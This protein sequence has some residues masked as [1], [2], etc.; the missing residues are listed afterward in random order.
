MTAKDFLLPDLGEGLTE[1]EIVTWLVSVGDPVTVDQPVAEVETAKAVV[2]VPSPFAGTVTA[3]HGEVGEEVEVGTPLVSIEVDDAR[4]P[5]AAAGTAPDEA[6]AAEMVPEPES[7]DESDSGSVLVGY[8]TGQSSRARRRRTQAAPPEQRPERLSSGN[9]DGRAVPTT[10]PPMREGKP[11][12]KPP[13]RKLAK[14]LGVDLAEVPASGPDGI[15]TREDVHAFAGD[16]AADE[17]PAPVLASASADRE[18]RRPLRGVRK[19]IAER[20]TMS[21]REIPEAT[22]EVDCDATA[23]WQARNEINAAQDE[24]AVSPL[25]LIMRACVVGLRRY[26]ELNAR[27][28]TDRNE[29][30]VQHFVNLGFAAQTDRGL[31]VP[32]IKGADRMTT[33]EIAAELNRLA[34]AARDAK[35][36]PDE[37]TGGTFTLSNYGSFGVDGG[38]AVINHPEAAILGVGRIADKPWVVDGELAVRKVMNLSVAF[39]H[40]ICDGG[41]AAGFLRFVADCVESPALFLAQL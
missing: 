18:E 21:R 28:D 11:L 6:E 33:L 35:V 39:D 30:V 31:V 12:A 20:M 40:R 23:L 3:L 15:I 37:M 16:G 34:G 36:T 9:G 14:D 19:A 5:A 26:P 7:D 41:E 22:A 8:G 24:T 27:L 17:A 1:G 10:H 29:I 38:S 2:E 13:V 4:A 25:A 32:V